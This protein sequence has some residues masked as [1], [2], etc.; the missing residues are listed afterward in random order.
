[1]KPDLGQAQHSFIKLM[2]CMQ[3]SLELF[4]EVEG[5]KFYRHDLKRSINMTK[6]SVEKAIDEA[7]GFVDDTEKHE[8]Y[9]SIERGIHKIVNESIV[10]LFAKGYE[11]IVTKIS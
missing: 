4:D 8:T 5:T 2:I 10:D 6:K 11:P 1:M 7:F 3:A 9:M